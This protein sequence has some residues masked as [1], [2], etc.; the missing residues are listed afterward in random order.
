[1][2]KA[3]VTK[4]TKAKKVIKHEGN[5]FTKRIEDIEKGQGKLYFKYRGSTIGS[6]FSLK[7]GYVYDFSELSDRAK[8]YVIKQYG[9]VVFVP[10]DE[11]EGRAGIITKSGRGVR[12]GMSSREVNQLDYTEINPSLPTKKKVNRALS[13]TASKEDAIVT[14]KQLGIPH[15]NRNVI[16]E[17][18]EEKYLQLS[19]L[20]NDFT[21]IN[22][23]KEDNTKN[24]PIEND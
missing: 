12:D 14:Q 9:K 19:K 23:R 22:Q 8:V 10:R 17:I 24:I 3:P 16:S 18:S 6:T 4:T 1:M 21:V 7:Y 20:Q 11:Y 13:M 15:V 2:A 5:D